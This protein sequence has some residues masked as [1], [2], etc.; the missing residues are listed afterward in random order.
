MVVFQLSFLLF[1]ALFCY[2]LLDVYDSDIHFLEII[3]FIWIATM[4]LEEIREVFSWK[5]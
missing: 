5:T 3:L 1:L 2:M 4:I